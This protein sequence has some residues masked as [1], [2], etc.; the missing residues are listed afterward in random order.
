LLL[1]RQ[2]ALW[3]HAQIHPHDRHQSI[4]KGIIASSQQASK[5]PHDRHMMIDVTLYPDCHA[6]SSAGLHISQQ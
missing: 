3:G 4:T 6:L 5:N 1:Y 2:S